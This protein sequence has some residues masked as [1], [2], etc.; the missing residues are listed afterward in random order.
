ML[1][2]T[3]N[4]RASITQIDPAARKKLRGPSVKLFDEYSRRASC[5]LYAVGG[6]LVAPMIRIIQAS[7]LN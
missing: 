7:P 1:A 5:L 6:E 2:A 3:T 4:V